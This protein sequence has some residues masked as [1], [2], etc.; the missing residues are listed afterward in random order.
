MQEL[1]AA[2]S[3]G[4]GK[5]LAN[6][7]S[8]EFLLRLFLQNT[9][10][11]E[12]TWLDRGPGE[13]AVGDIVAETPLTDW[14]SLGVLIDRYN[15]AIGQHSSL[16]V[17]KTVVDLRDAL[18]HGR[19]FMPSMQDPPILIKFEKPCDGRTRVTFRKSG[20]EWLHQAIKDVHAE[21]AKVQAAL[22]EH[23]AAQQ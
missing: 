10:H 13:M 20:A 5:T 19:M 7:Q 16:R 15:A 17:S 22:D 18:A 21:T 11:P 4:L 1:F 14:S 6:L 9:Q 12:A 23:G 3:E 8:L 2:Y